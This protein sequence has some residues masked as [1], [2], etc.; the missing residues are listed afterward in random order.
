MTNDS[1]QEFDDRLTDAERVEFLWRALGGCMRRDAKLTVTTLTHFLEEHGSGYP[2]VPLMQ[3]RVREDAKLWALSAST[4]EL[5]AYIA[6]AILEMEISPLTDR[7]AKRMA[8]L[9]FKVMNPETKE[10]FKGW[11]ATQ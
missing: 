1:N 4:V 5:E 9:G 10:K 6:A 2:D 8:A 7:A 3:E 11:V